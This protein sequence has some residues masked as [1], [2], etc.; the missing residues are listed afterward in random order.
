MERFAGQIRSAPVKRIIAVVACVASMLLVI[1]VARSTFGNKSYRGKWVCLACEHDFSS[2]NTKNPPMPCPRCAGEAVKLRFRHCPHCGEKVAWA[3]MRLTEESQAQ[4]DRVNKRI[5]EGDR[6]AVP[7][8]GVLMLP[9]EAQY[10]Q[11]Q[12]DGSIGWSPWVPVN[13]Q[14][15]GKALSRSPCPICLE[16]MPPLGGAGAR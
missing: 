9:I 3:R 4:R 2:S 14:Q 7:M 8:T 13:A 15:A 10:P 11:Q 5:A 16:I 12:S 6:S 1:A